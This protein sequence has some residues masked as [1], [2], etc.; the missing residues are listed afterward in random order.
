MKPKTH[1]TKR[2]AAVACTDLLA[3]LRSQLRVQGQNGNWNYDPYMHG[4]YNGLECALATLEHRDPE[5]RSAPKKW[6]WTRSL[7]KNPRTA[8]HMA[9]VPA[10]RPPATDV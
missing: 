2:A 6:L 8:A 7:P 9:N 4:M 5:Y 10:Q 1:K 3:P